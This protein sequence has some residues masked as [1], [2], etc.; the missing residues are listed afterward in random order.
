MTGAGMNAM[1]WLFPRSWWDRYGEE[2]ADLVK[3]VSGTTPRWRL[4]MD[5]V[6][7]AL[8]VRLRGLSMRRSFTDPAVRRGVYDGLILSA[9]SAVLV[10]LTN[11]V[12][13]P[14]PNE[15]DSDPEY[16]WQYAAA[17]LALVAIFIWIGVRGRRRGGTLFAGARAGIS[18]GVVVAVMV[19]LT[20]LAMNN[21][22]LS[23]V[24]QQHDKRVS[25]A[26][27][28][29]TSMRA[30]L[31]VTQLESLL[32]LVPVGVIAGLTLGLVGGVI[33]G[34]SRAGQG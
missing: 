9:V 31:S 29:F 25:F 27:S 22:F 16:L 34:R 17:L 14:G 13:P 33:A 24:S 4:V 19:T 2:F 11:V 23:I 7:C 6:S 18:A 20:F 15:S 30:Y 5:V 28:H 8:D 32:I 1:R 21:V 12:F 3:D 10:L 26:A